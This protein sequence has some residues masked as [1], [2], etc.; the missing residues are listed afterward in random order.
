[1]KTLRLEPID[2]LTGHLELPGSKSVSNRALLLSALAD[3]T[4]EV[5]NLLR[6]EDTEHMLNALS[7]LGV[8]LDDAGREVTVTGCGGPLVTRPGHWELY[9]GLA[10]TALRPLCAALTLGSGTF[11]LDGSERMRERPIGDLVDALAPLGARIR[12]LGEP[13]FPPV[14]VTGT[15]LT[16]GVTSIRGDVSSQFLTSLLMAAPLAAGPVRI[17]V[18]G[19]QVSKPYLDITLQMMRQFGA[20]VSHD[21]YQHFDVGIGGYVSPGTYLVEGD[22]SS[23]SYFLAAGAIRGPGIRV[24]GIGAGSLQ[25]DI[26]FLDVLEAMGARVEREAEAVSVRPP[27]DGVLH[28]VDLDLNHIPDAAM[29][30]AVLALFAR[31]TTTIRNV[32]NWRVKETD[33]LA[34]MATEL[35]KLGAAVAEG[36]DSISVTPPERPREA[37]IATYGDH[38]M[39]MCFSLVALAG[40]PVTVQDP[41]CVAKTFPDYFQRFQALARAA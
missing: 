12:Y 34:A 29:T 10:G 19:E 41:D 37:E 18:I 5:R 9:L 22:A 17:D 23:A 38:R 30:L 21:R 36:P 8:A 35:R 28:A 16:G 31:G 15:G 13:G 3:G 7:T 25:G 1:M 11:V 27:A 4:T 32:A 40:V 20:D 39:A 14:E 26:A 24:S 2:H 33:R 6:S